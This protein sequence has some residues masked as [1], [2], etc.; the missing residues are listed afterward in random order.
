[1]ASLLVQSFFVDRGGTGCLSDH[2]AK[3]EASG[4]KKQTGRYKNQKVA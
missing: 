1:M 3:V 2:A 4:S